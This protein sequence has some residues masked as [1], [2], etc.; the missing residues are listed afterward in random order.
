MS[1]TFEQ[2]EQVHVYANGIVYEGHYEGDIIIPGILMGT[3]ALI[4]LGGQY[5]C[6]GIFNKASVR[7][8]RT[9]PAFKHEGMKDVHHT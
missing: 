7:R 5:N 3:Q 8:T 1:T 4:R 6:L 9:L 2:G